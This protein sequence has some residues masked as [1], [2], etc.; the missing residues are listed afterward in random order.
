MLSPERVIGDA[1]DVIVR[2]FMAFIAIVDVAVIDV[3]SD[4]V[5][6]HALEIRV[7]S[8]DDVLV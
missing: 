7:M 2:S 5:V 1:V 8:P 3:W 4:R 6:R